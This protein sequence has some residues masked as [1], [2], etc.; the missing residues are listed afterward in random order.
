MTQGLLERTKVFIS[1]SHRDV[2]WLERLRVHL[3]PL[4]REHG[5]DIW[6]DTRIKPG[7]KWREE[8]MQALAAAKVAVLLVSADFLASDFI[9]S[10]ELP[11]LLIAAEE[12]G[13]TILSIILS[14]CRFTQTESISRFQAVNSASR[15]LSSMSRSDQEG[16]FVKVSECIE[17]ALGPF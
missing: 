13:T 14:P 3:K 10:D 17:A 11:L 16:V 2:E 1:Y 6:D 4:E 9:A 12:E 7:S 5:I 15:P 8:I